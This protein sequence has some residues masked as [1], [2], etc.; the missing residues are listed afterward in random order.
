MHLSKKLRLKKKY[1]KHT[2]FNIDLYGIDF[3][4]CCKYEI[5]FK[6][7]YEYT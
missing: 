3:L 6:Y 7:V 5:H 4:E 1:A 2:L